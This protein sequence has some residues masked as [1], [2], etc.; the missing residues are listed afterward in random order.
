MSE[1]NFPSIGLV[2]IIN[3]IIMYVEYTMFQS[4]GGRFETL[5][6]EIFLV[7]AFISLVVMALISVNFIITSIMSIKGNGFESVYK[8]VSILTLIIILVFLLQLFVN[9]IGF[10]GAFA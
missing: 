6:E 7:F 9:F 2:L 8:V 3:V 10:T 5:E 4:F 1:R